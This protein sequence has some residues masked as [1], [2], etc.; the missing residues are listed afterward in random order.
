MYDPNL[1]LQ[2]LT[3]AEYRS[4]DSNGKCFPPANPIYNKISKRMDEFNCYISPKHV[5]IILTTNRRGI[6]ASVLQ[7]F[8]IKKKILRMNLL[9]QARM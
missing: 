6:Y 7:A 8:N 2:I 4:L 5:Y 3:T 9:T 1:L